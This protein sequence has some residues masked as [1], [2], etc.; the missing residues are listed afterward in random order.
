[1]QPYG[2]GY[3]N[4]VPGGYGELMVLSA[5]LALPVPNGLA[6]EHAALTEPMAVGLHAVEK[7]RLESARRRAGG[8]LRARSAWR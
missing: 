7:A 2:I 3:S 4:D 6:T 5:A 1:M 8:R